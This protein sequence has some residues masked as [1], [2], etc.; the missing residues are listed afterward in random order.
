MSKQA[1]KDAAKSM[2]KVLEKFPEERIKHVISFKDVQIERFQK[3][4]G[5]KMSTGAEAQKPSI[6]DIKDIINRTSKPLGLSS[7]LLKEMQSS[8]PQE[9]FTEVSINEQIKALNNLMANKL[10]NYYDAGDKIYKPAGN[11]Y[12][13]QRLLDEL[14]GKRKENIFTA[15]RTVVF[16]K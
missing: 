8:S 15:F 16:G 11:P 1:V 2:V 6:S 5:A 3:I 4:S 9:E 14:E 10:K 13:Y 12:Y 7:K